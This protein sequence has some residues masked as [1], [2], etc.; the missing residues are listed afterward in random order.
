MTTVYRYDPMV[1]FEGR[2]FWETYEKLR[3]GFTNGEYVLFSGKTFLSK[4]T[5]PYPLKYEGLRS[6][7]PEFV[8]QVYEGDVEQYKRLHKY[9]RETSEMSK[10]DL[11][12]FKELLDNIEKKTGKFYQITVKQASGEDIVIGDLNKRSSYTVYDM[13]PKYKSLEGDYSS[14]G[15]INRKSLLLMYEP[16]A[17][18]HEFEKKEDFTDHYWKCRKCHTFGTEKQKNSR[19]HCYTCKESIPELYSQ[20][21]IFCPSSGSVYLSSGGSISICQNVGFIRINK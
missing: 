9:D 1:A 7:T 2:D 3:G 13:L 6:Y 17:E 5:E 12:L 4:S 20:G 16:Y 8:H 11:T 18:D 10:E 19:A 14:L 15:E 21:P